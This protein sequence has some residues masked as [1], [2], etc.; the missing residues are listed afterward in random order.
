MRIVSVHVDLFVKL[1]PNKT[2]S[3]PTVN[4]VLNLKATSNCVSGDSKET[5]N[6]NNKCHCGNAERVQISKHGTRGGSIREEACVESKLEDFVLE[7]VMPSREFL[8]LFK[9]TIGTRNP[10]SEG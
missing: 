4:A 6:G 9:R 10:L 3:A 1:E 2:P 7:I 8:S 5:H